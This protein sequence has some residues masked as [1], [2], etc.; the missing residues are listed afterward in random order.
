[1]AGGALAGLGGTSNLIAD[2][3]SDLGSP[4]VNQPANNQTAYSTEHQYRNVLLRDDGVGKADEQTK[5]E[6]D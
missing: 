1:M 5:Y 3:G 6:A 4:I 2:S